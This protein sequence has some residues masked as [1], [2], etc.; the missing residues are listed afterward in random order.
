MSIHCNTRGST[1]PP[2]KLPSFRCFPRT[3]CR[4]CSLEKLEPENR[5]LLELHWKRTSELSLRMTGLGWYK[6]S[7]FFYP[8]P[9]ALVSHSPTPTCR[10]NSIRPPSWRVRLPTDLACLSHHIYFDPLFPLSTRFSIFFCDFA[11]T[12]SDGAYT[13]LV[14]FPCGRCLLCARCRCRCDM[15]RASGSFHPCQGW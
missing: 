1:Q 4:K 7:R 5:F 8:A 11:S 14:Q 3:G 12:R 9:R 13:S 10:P 2:S 15:Y 6:I